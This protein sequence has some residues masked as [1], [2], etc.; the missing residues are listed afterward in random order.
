MEYSAGV[1]SQWEWGDLD[2]LLAVLFQ[3]P[4]KL[5]LPSD[6]PNRVGAIRDFL[7]ALG[8]GTHA[9]VLRLSDPLPFLRESLLW[10]RGK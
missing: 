2:N 1:R 4:A 9:E 6:R 5:A 3:S 7:R 8:S 10:I